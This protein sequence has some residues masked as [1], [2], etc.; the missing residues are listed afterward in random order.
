MKA[1][2]LLRKYINEN[3][4]KIENKL[5]QLTEQLKQTRQENDFNEIHLN[6]FGQKLNQ[7]EEQ[8]NRPS[9]VSIE[10]DSSSFINKIYVVV[11]AG[12]S[13]NRSLINQSV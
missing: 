12:K 5:T 3:I 10:Q 1:R 2:Q 13:I 4:E 7:L 11:S 8:L 9:N 6:R